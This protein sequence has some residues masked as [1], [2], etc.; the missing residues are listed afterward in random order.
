[1]RSPETGCELMKVTGNTIETPT[2]EARPWPV[3][4]GPVAPWWHTAIVAA[5]V[6]GI[7]ILSN[8][9]AKSVGLGGSHIRRYAFTIAW[10]WLLALLAWWGLRLCRTPVREILGVYRAGVKGWARDFGVALL[11]W[12]LA[13]I[14]LSA[15]AILLRLF[16][17]VQPQKA[18]LAIAPQTLAQLFLWIA[19]CATAGVVEEFV[20][21]GYLLQ[22]FASI[23][24]RLWIG[25][26]LSSLLFGAGHG[27]EGAGG[28]IVIAVYGVMFCLLAIERRGLRAGMMAHAWHDA[29]TGIALFLA[30]HAHLF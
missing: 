18:V 4:R 13:I 29:L 21:R 30:K 2:P 23:R 9:Q 25:I 19:L 8:I 20:F 14:V 15:L 24:G 16:H 28:M 27:Y 10:E 22:Q 17:L 3:P 12:I 11:F 7:S 5:V 6:I 26:A 1:M